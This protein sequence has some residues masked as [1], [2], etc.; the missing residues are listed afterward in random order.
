M[1]I[2]QHQETRRTKTNRLTFLK[3]YSGSAVLVV[4]CCA[5]DL[6]FNYF[7]VHGTPSLL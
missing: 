7:F 1:I 2:P 3:T 4:V 6:D 5:P